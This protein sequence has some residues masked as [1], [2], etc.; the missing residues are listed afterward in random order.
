MAFSVAG[1][2]TKNFGRRLLPDGSFVTTEWFVLAFVPVIP[3][4][5]WRVL[6]G[7]T[8]GT[9]PFRS[10]FGSFRAIPA[11]LDWRTVVQIYAWVIGTALAF[12]FGVPLLN[13]LVERL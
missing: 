9:D 11:P 8:G 3:V 1:M 10:S 6:E 4:R 13:R 7:D 12:I 2:G 5:S